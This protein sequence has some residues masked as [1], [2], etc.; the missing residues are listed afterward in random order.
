MA[1]PANYVTMKEFNEF[2]KMIL[3]NLKGIEKSA[4]KAFK[5]QAPKKAKKKAA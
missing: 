2:K 1:R 4:V 3:K 5:L